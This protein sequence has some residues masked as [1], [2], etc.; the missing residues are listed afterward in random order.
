VSDGTHIEWTDAT[1]NI[2]NGCSVVSPGCTNCYAMRLAGTRLKHHPSREGLTIDTKAGPVW[3]GEV[4]FND[5]VL[6][7]PLQ[8][9]AAAQD[10]RLR[11]RRPVP[12]ERARRVARSNL[13][14]H[15]AAPQ[16]VIFQVL[17]KRPERMRACYMTDRSVARSDG[18]GM[19][20]EMLWQKAKT[21][22]GDRIM[23]GPWPLPNVWLGVSVEDQKRAD[24]RIPVLLDTPAAVRWLSYEPLLGPVSL[25]AFMPPAHHHPIMCALPRSTNSSRRRGHRSAVCTRRRK[26]STGSSPAARAVPARV[27]CTP[28][29]RDR[30]ATSALPPVCR[31]CSSSGGVGADSPAEHM[32]RWNWRHAPSS[33]GSVAARQEIAWPDGS[34]SAMVAREDHGRCRPASSPCAHHKRNAVAVA[35][36][37]D[38]GPSTTADPEHEHPRADQSDALLRSRWVRA[39]RPGPR[40]LDHCGAPKRTSRGGLPETAH[41]HCNNADRKASILMRCAIYAR[42]SSDRQSEAS[43][44]DQARLCRE[45]ASSEGWTVTAEFLDP[46]ISGATRDRPG[47][48]RLLARAADFDV[49]LCESLDRLSRDEEDIAHITK[50]LRYA[51]RSSSPWPTAR[52]GGC[53]SASRA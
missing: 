43:A 33:E 41:G 20:L 36:S 8:M 42:Y 13:R 47:L 31:F 38:V 30:C 23:E 22:V 4:R 32:R 39:R 10:L 19:A 28:I 21:P 12:R 1:W 15:G 24:E 16:H 48:K 49:V 46:A 52:S 25:T 50:R 18:R 45:R 34:R 9:A 2:V 53:T 29:G 51:R 3:T 5:K 7:D 11:P 37:M 40:P 26:R 14:R 17:T 6:L 44:E 27:R 35:C